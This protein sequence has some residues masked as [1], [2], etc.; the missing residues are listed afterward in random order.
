[1]PGVDQAGL[2]GPAQRLWL[3]GPSDQ[4]RDAAPTPLRSVSSLR[5]RRSLTGLAQLQ[6]ATARNRVV[7]IYSRPSI[8]HLVRE[9]GEVKGY[10]RLWM[11]KIF[12][13]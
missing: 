2:D 5:L 3:P 9:R 4:S 1:M 10:Q 13:A 8:A 6:I 7:A 12:I 11:V